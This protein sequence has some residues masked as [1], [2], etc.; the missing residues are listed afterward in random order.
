[1]RYKP[2]KFK[3][4]YAGWKELRIFYLVLGISGA[5]ILISFLT[6]IME[7]GSPL[8]KLLLDFQKIS[9][10]SIFP[11]PF[12]IQNI[13]WLMFGMAVGDSFYRNRCAN[14]ERNSTR[15][16]LLPETHNEILTQENLP[17][18]MEKSYVYSEKDKLF[19]A[20]LIHSTGMS[21]QTHAS[22]Q[23]A[24]EV[25]S[26]QVEL[27]LQR[28]DLKYTLLRYIAWLLPTLGFIGT[29]VGI[30]AS[31]AS[32]EVVKSTAIVQQESS[33]KEAALGSVEKASRQKSSSEE[34]TTK[35]GVAFNTTILALIMSI[36]VVLLSQFLQKKE[37]QIINE[38]SEYCLKNLI[39]RLYNPED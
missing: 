9:V 10:S 34:V 2:V 37:E 28:S 23:Q 27:E 6:A 19:L 14:K 32:L 24:H 36:V 38:Q 33:E 18:I 17:E 21:F 26:S 15:L 20:K 4:I 39:V 8:S 29:V 35:L 1:M 30:S 13:M 31:L 3:E 22:A 16:N 11:Y 7:R 5:F 12:T 25:M